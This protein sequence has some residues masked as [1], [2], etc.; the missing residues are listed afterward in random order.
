MNTSQFLKVATKV[1]INRDQEAEREADRKKKRKVDLLAEALAEQSGRPRHAGHD[2]G[3][4]NPYGEQS[5][6]LEWRHP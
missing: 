1:F 6:P 3:R 4:G 5:V 2:R